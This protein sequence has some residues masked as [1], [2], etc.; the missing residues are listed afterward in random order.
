MLWY[1]LEASHQ[2]V[3][4]SSHKIHVCCHGEIR[5]KNT[6]WIPLLSG[7]ILVLAG[8]AQDMRYYQVSVF[9]YFFL[10]T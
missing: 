10:Q 2:G 8:I 5:I 1:S 3:S 7:A 6:M 9:Y 4:N